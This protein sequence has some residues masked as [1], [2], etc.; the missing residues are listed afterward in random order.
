MA[1]NTAARIPRLTSEGNGKA[2]IFVLRAISPRVSEGYGIATNTSLLGSSRC[3]WCTG[4][5]LPERNFGAGSSSPFPAAGQ[6]RKDANLGQHRLHVAELVDGE[7][8]KNVT[9]SYF[10]G[11]E[12]SLLRA[13]TQHRSKLI[14]DLHVVIRKVLD[15]GSKRKR[16]MAT[17]APESFKIGDRV[18]QLAA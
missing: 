9:R 14:D 13:P 16:Q 17:R 12:E 1:S 8:R 11:A 6:R 7:A 4:S 10:L 3:V 18:F 15:R 5:R 2:G